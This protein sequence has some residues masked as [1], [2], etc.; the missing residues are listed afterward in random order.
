MRPSLSACCCLLLPIAVLFPA[1]D[2]SGAP[3]SLSDEDDPEDIRSILQIVVWGCSIVVALVTI[4]GLVLRRLRKPNLVLL[5][6]DDSEEMR[7]PRPP[8]PTRVPAVLRLRNLGRRTAARY[9]MDIHIPEDIA[10]PR[11]HGWLDVLFHEGQRDVHWSRAFS[12]GYWIV[13]YRGDVP[14]YRKKPYDLC[15]VSLLAEPRRP[16]AGRYDLPYNITTDDR[17]RSGCLVVHFEE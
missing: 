13:R 6:G 15:T 8:N 17:H 5:F 12:G 14:A 3:D 2:L 7:V 11:E 4:T 9:E 10:I 1:S 16:K